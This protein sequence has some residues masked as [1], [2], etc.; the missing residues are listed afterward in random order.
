MQ[1][2]TAFSKTKFCSSRD[3][4]IISFLHFMSK[5]LKLK[6]VSFLCLL[7]GR[8]LPVPAATALFVLWIW[9]W[10]GREDSSISTAEVPILSWHW[11]YAP[12]RWKLIRWS[13]M[14]MFFWVFGSWV[15]G[16][17]DWKQP[18]ETW[19]PP[20]WTTVGWTWDVVSRNSSNLLPDLE[21]ILSVSNKALSSVGLGPDLTVMR[22]CRCCN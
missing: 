14:E 20:Y 19:Q 2:V 15:W 9:Q 13:K 16:L 1:K 10:M 6:L 21:Q 3:I 8:G 11:K 7:S 22:A 18:G 12:S 5:Q 4:V 17:G